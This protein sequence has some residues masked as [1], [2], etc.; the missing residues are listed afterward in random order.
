MTRGRSSRAALAAATGIACAVA[1]AVAPASASVERSP[2]VRAGALPKIR[3]TVGPGFEISINRESVPA[4]RY[5]LIVRD[6]GTIHNF[7]FFGPGV[8]HE[9]SVPG[10]GRHVWRATLSLGTYIANCE[11][12]GSMTT[13]LEVT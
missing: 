10:T 11:P 3:G 5:K 9:T 2:D 8:D 13:S 6:R 12:H 1:V 4:G 7:H